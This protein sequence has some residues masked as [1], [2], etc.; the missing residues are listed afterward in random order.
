[1]RIRNHARKLSKL[2]AGDQKGPNPLT[3][4]EHKERKEEFL[5]FEKASYVQ[6]AEQ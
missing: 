2:W 3:L 1:M 4:S 6:N 5:T